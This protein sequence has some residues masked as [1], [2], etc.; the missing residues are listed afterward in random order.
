MRINIVAVGKIKEKYFT[1]AIAE[2]KKRLSRFTEFNVIE[3]E[4]YKNNKTTPEQINITINTEGER[5]LDKAKGYIIALDKGGKLMSSEEIA[6]DIKDITTYKSSEI[7]FLIGGSH[8][9][10][11][12]VLQRAD[13]KISFGKV[14]YPHQLMRVILSEQIYRAFTIINGVPYH[15]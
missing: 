5:L 9:L 13:E 15:K 14:T 12:Q 2:Y 10:S 11:K 4:E 7:T 6:E 3:V 8:G 1:D